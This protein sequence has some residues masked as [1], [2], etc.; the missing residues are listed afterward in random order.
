M[1]NF[2]EIDSFQVETSTFCNVACPLCPRHFMGTSIVRPTLRQRHILAPQW[3]KFLDGMKHI[4]TIDNPVNMVFCGCHGDPVMTPDWEE[5]I[6]ETAKRPYIIDVETNGSMRSP[7][8]WARVGKAMGYAER[9]QGIEKIMTFSIDGLAD[10][11]K[12]YRIGIKHER[13][14]A[15]AQAY[16]NAGGKARWK[17][18]V[19]EHN[20]HQVD[21]AQ[22]LA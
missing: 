11:N 17:M 12:L 9:A 5:I 19:F 21:E 3:N 6:I 4:V 20:K 22:Q 8:S 7:E 2:K 10:T 15:N 1:F 14:M 16:I 18:I 13:V